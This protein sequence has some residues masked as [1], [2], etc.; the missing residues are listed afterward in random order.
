[1]GDTERRARAGTR[2]GRAV[3]RKTRLQ[4]TEADLTP[5]RG[6]AA[7]ALVR[8]L[9]AESW[10]LAGLEPPSYTRERIPWRFVPRRPA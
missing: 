6:P 1:M 8:Q 2:Q 3:L 5:V 10:S 9:T 4:P 7:V